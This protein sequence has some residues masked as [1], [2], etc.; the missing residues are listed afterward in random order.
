MKNFCLISEKS[1]LF[2]KKYFPPNKYKWCMGIVVYTSQC[3]GSHAVLRSST[4]LRLLAVAGCL[5]AQV[6]ASLEAWMHQ[7]TTT[8]KK[9]GYTLPSVGLSSACHHICILLFSVLL[10][11]ILPDWAASAAICT[12]SIL[13]LPTL[14][15]WPLRW[16]PFV[17]KLPDRCW[18]CLTTPL[19]PNTWIC[20]SCRLPALPA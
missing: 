6:W 7:S 2:K 5:Q 8:F 12:W 16:L 17:T 18:P 9:E 19:L 3:R 4:S 11:L 14:P 1:V 15:D 13:P 20:P 10:L